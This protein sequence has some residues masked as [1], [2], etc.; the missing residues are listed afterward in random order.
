M[1]ICWHDIWRKKGLA[2]PRLAGVEDPLPH[3]LKLN[4]YDSKTST[5]SL[6]DWTTLVNHIAE[7]LALR[8]TDSLYEVGCG[9]GA[10]LY[11]LR[12]RCR[13]VAGLD[14]SAPLLDAARQ[15]LND[16]DLELGEA[17]D[18]SPHP[19]YDVVTSL[20]VFIYFPD[21]DYARD[22]VERMIAKSRRVVAI[23]DVNDA[24]RRDEALRL[25]RA[26]QAAAGA[27]PGPEQLFLPCQFFLN[28]AEAHG[29]RC[30]VSR[31]AMPNSIN[32]RYRYDVFLF[33]EP[34]ESRANG[35]RDL[36]STLMSLLPLPLIG[37]APV[38]APLASLL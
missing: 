24:A 12:E 22:V 36:R 5:T 13:K 33:K 17:R 16:V 8:P 11:G 7:S 9:A 29:L 34:A 15:V 18:L 4:G 14:Y 26:A 2:A 38:L 21:E 1:K 37:E 28:L 35:G 30:R 27:A 19:R 6:D 32:S 10:L 31:T 20:G 25:R 3:L 23:L